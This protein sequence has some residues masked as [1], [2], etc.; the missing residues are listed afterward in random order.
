MKRLFIATLLLSLSPLG[1]AE[2]AAVELEAPRAES[3]KRFST[4]APRA[5]LGLQVTKPDETVSAHLPSLPPGVGFLVKAIDENGPAEAAG[6]REL[7]LISRIGDQ[8]LVNEAQ[9]ATLLR[10]SKPGEEVVITG[11]RGGKPLEVK[12]TLGEAPALKR[13]FSGEMVES[14]ILPGA[15]DGPMRVINLAEK[16]ASFSTDDGRAVVRREGEVYILKIE[17]PE[18]EAIFDGQIADVN[19]LE[20]IPK[21]W[22]RKVRVLCRSLDHALE[23]GGLPQ[24]QP[25]PRV[26]PPVEPQTLK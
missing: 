3:M 1:H 6:L 17:G 19:A 5:W 24:R 26:V 25:R 20:A 18:N 16:S 2:P 14:A 21:D 11:F 23:A 15:C 10:L 22:H 12:L 4:R 8:M 7:D 9:L 13:R